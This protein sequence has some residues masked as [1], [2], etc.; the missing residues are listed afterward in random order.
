M[1]SEYG[2]SNPVSEAGI[3]HQ[4][5]GAPLSLGGQKHQWRKTAV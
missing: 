1:S 3:T 5:K 4:L 2:D